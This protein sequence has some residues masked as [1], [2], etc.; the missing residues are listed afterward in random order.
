MRA[1]LLMSVVSV[2]VT[3]GQP[4]NSSVGTSPEWDVKSNMA[5]LV[6]DVR[7]LEPVLLEVKPA[8]WVEK[9]APGTYIKQLQSS[10]GSLQQ[11]IAATDA[12][13][14]TPDRLTFALDALFR[15]ERMEL[16]LG[17]LKEGARKYQS[18]EVADQLTS[19]IA[20]NS[21]HRDRLR[22]H[23]T[24]L[25]VAREQEISLMDQEAQRCR[26]M[27]SRQPAQANQETRKTG[28]QERK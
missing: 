13:A 19:L 28:K 4:A 11:L 17:S 15:L 24:D 3:F 23:I 21:I 27:L 10:R 22:Q 20:Q 6:A 25:A 1:S 14:Q 12:L 5:S 26:S 7:R 9:G 16:L 18:P 8:G 2:S